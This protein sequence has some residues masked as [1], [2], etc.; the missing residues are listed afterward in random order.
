VQSSNPFNSP[1]PGQ[2]QLQQQQQSFFA[3]P[4]TAS[5]AP[6]PGRQEY[7]SQQQLQPQQAPTP[8]QQHQQAFGG[9]QNPW[10]QQQQQ[11]VPYQQT[12]AN[13]GPQSQQG[14]QQFGQMP[15]PAQPMR[16]DKSSILALYNMPSFTPQQPLQTLQEDPNS[17]PP[18]K[19]AA[20]STPLLATQCNNAS[21]ASWTWW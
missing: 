17:A 10:Q 6:M 16:H 12:G 1:H 19:P 2:W 13:F 3:Q 20:T 4:A 21:A 14:L 18:P 9:A 11:Q 8:Q 5:P 7:F 15:P